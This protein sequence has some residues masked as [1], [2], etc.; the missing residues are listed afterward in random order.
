M[1]SALKHIVLF[2]LAAVFLFVMFVIGICIADEHEKDKN[3]KRGNLR[4]TVDK[5]LD[6]RF[7]NNK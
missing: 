7:K 1:E 5:D 4:I 3:R 2:V 6:K